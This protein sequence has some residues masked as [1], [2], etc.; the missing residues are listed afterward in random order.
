MMF[1]AETG[2]WTNLDHLPSVQYKFCCQVA[3]RWKGR[4][5]VYIFDEWNRTCA[6]TVIDGPGHW[7]VLEAA[8]TMPRI[9]ACAVQLDDDT[10]VICGGLWRGKYTASCDRFNLTTHTISWFPEM[11]ERRSGHAGVHYNGT[12]VV[13]GGSIEGKDGV[14]LCEQFDPSVGDWGWFAPLNEGRWGAGAAVV[15]GKIY[16]AGGFNVQSVEVYNGLAW[17]VIAELPL[18]VYGT[19]AVALGGRL[20]VCSAT[21]A[22]SEEMRIFNPVTD[23]WTFL[24]RPQKDRPSNNVVSF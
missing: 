10:I 9:S 7:T 19:G 13:I 24:E 17:T 23:T 20:A 22:F 15:D 4:T 12:I 5:R 18:T 3:V 16:V 14:T 21:G 8:L 1:D 11:V 6:F 2:R